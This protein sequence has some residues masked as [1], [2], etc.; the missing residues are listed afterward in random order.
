MVCTRACV[1]CARDRLGGSKWCSSFRRCAPAPTPLL[2]TAL[3]REMWIATHVRS[4]F[5]TESLE[6][7]R[8]AAQLPVRRAA[9]LRRRNARTAPAA[10]ARRFRSPARLAI[11]IKLTRVAGRVCIALESSTATSSPRTS[12]A[13]ARRRA[14]APSISAPRGCSSATRTLEIISPARSATW[15]R[16]CSLGTVADEHGSVRARCHRVPACSSAAPIR[17]ANGSPSRSR[18][19]ARPRRWR[20]HA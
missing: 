14:E 1:S 13:R 16:N 19:S 17:T 4:P 11:A 6:P 15:R 12:S 7:P 2:G 18:A 8:R 9:V 5:V 10:P 20:S 3:L